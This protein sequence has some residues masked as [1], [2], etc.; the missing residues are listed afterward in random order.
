MYGV[1][2]DVY[3]DGW[4]GVDLYFDFLYVDLCDLY[5]WFV[6]E[7][8]DVCWC[9]VGLCDVGYVFIVWL[10]VGLVW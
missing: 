7:V 1:V 6:D 5:V 8:V 2:V 9:C 10:V 3:G 4:Y